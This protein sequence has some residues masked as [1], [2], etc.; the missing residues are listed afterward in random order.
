M[1]YVEFNGEQAAIGLGIADFGDI[2]RRI[3]PQ[4]TTGRVGNLAI[5]LRR[6][7]SVAEEPSIAM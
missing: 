2:Q 5:D 6:G 3:S 7:L 1:I 4:I